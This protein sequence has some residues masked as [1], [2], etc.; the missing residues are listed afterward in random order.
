MFATHFPP[1]AY[2][3]PTD[4]RFR[5]RGQGGGV[6]LDAVRLVAKTLPVA[7]DLPEAVRARFGRVV[8]RVLKSSI[9]YTSAQLAG[10]LDTRF[11][12]PILIE[13][14]EGGTRQGVDATGTPWERVL[15]G[16]AYGFLP[17]TVAR[18]EEPLDV[19]TGPMPG[20]PTAFVLTQVR[21]APAAVEA[22]APADAPA[23]VQLDEYKLGIGF[24]TAEDFERVYLANWAP[25]LY[26]GITAIP[27]EVMQG[28]LGFELGPGEDGAVMKAIRAVA[29]EAGYFA[30]TSSGAVFGRV[31]KR[32][33]VK[34]SGEVMAAVVSAFDA[35]ISTAARR[36]NGAS[37]TPQP[38]NEPAPVEPVEN[39]GKGAMGLASFAAG[40]LML[41]GQGAPRVKRGKA[42]DALAKALD[43]A[44]TKA[45]QC[46]K[47]LEGASEY[48]GPTQ[49]ID[50][51][52]EYEDHP[53]LTDPLSF[54]YDRPADVGGWLGGIESEDTEREA[55]KDPRWICFVDVAG[56][57]LLWERR[58]ENGA[59]EGTPIEFKRPDL[60]RPELDDST[61]SDPEG[62]TFKSQVK[63][64]P[65]AKGLNAST[66]PERRIVYGVVLEPEPFDGKGDGHD[67]T[68]SA[69][70]VE[71]A[72][73]GYL[74]FYG[75]FDDR[76]GRFFPSTEIVPVESFVAPCDFVSGGVTIKKGSWV[77]AAR[78]V[79]DELWGRVLRGELTAWSIE[80]YA[81][82]VPNF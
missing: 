78:I 23:P 51:R 68:Y 40:G 58:A 76:H 35:Y 72:A 66:L 36:R 13:V 82:R 5:W 62:A 41:P 24:A 43:D 26:G 11:G 38:G 61:A 55:W 52:P 30:V 17:D 9:A 10:S 3:L 14:P 56:R 77:L 59:V 42:F 64:L 54:T 57:A 53:A 69:E 34:K 21:A 31:E 37:G 74:A 33:P 47:A 44:A 29:G 8:A 73:H 45:G 2:L 48:A 7:R 71:A 27:L 70:V 67:E 65:V 16:C 60:V 6:D 25:E 12:I 63:L 75:K 28:L 80:G 50:E 32:G 1:S 20:A 15:V 79:S 4:R 22:A 81:E 39:V 46:R 19:I 18:D 49:H